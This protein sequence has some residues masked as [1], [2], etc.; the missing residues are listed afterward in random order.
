LTATYSGNTSYASTSGTLTQTVNTAPLTT[1]T[2]Y[3]SPS[4]NPATVGQS[5]TFT[6]YVG[7]NGSTAELSGTVTLLDG[8]TS[9]GTAQVSAGQAKFTTSTLTVGDHVLTANYSGNANFAAASITRTETIKSQATPTVAITSSVNP[10]NVGQ[11]VTFTVIVTPP[12]G[13]TAATGGSVT[14]KDGDTVIGTNTFSNT[15]T[16]FTTSSLAAGTHNLT[17]TYNGNASYASATGT[18][19]QTVK[20][21]TTLTATT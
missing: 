3:I 15:G 16:S 20:T 2:V 1:P 8:S 10:S 7:A 11:S 14:L 4:I 13:S 18:L 19:T 21:T 12:T 9:L 6:V 17:A 5:V